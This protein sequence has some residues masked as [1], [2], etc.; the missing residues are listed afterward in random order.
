MALDFR[1][2]NGY[3]ES[4]D[5]P[6]LQ[7]ALSAGYNYGV[8]DQAGGGAF[9]VESLESSLK[10]LSFTEQNIRLWKNLPKM[11]AFNT[12]EEYNQLTAYGDNS[13]AFIPE[14]VMPE[15]QDSNY[16]RKVA[17]V[18]FLGTTRVV[19]HVMTMVRSAHGDVV[20]LENKNGIL[21]LLQQ[22]ERSLFWGNNTLTAG[23]SNV[24]GGKEGIEWAG[25]E[26]QIDPTMIIDAKGGS[27]TEGILED[28]CELIAE[29]FGRASC[30]YTPY[31]VASDFSKT[32]FPKERALL[33]TAS[34]GYAAGSVIN[35]FA[36]QFGNI[37]ILSDVFLTKNRKATGLAPS[38]ATSANAPQTPASISPDSTAYNS[39]QI[40]AWKNPGTRY[41]K[42]TAVNRFGESAATAASSGLVV[43]SGDVSA[44]NSSLLTITNPA[45][46]SGLVPDYFN[47][48]A[49][50]VS[51]TGSFYYLFSVAAA[52]VTASATTT[53]TDTGLYMTVVSTCY[54]GQMDNEVLAFKQLAPLM[55]MDL[56]VI[57]P[58]IRWMILLYGTL[59]MYAP[60]KWVRIINVGDIS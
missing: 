23:Y 30:L 43:S 34:G 1:G 35:T 42:A 44:G 60:R 51:S 10:V 2:I 15:T 3:G 58:A 49:C 21:W 45:S 38:A 40:G 57:G 59:V 28:A 55:K 14:A 47:V 27:L 53:Y 41:Y 39:A 29:Q 25:L 33:P 8:T 17:L 16:S 31:K 36:S 19:S 13:N 52:S 12:V 18:K 32:F 22:I 37:D 46:M 9:R 24:S 5:V 6:D 7:K 48:Y 26:A 50:D 4:R 11:P 56:A 20:A 54:L